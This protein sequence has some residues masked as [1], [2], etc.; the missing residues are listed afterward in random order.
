[1]LFAVI[2][3]SC[4]FIAKT[5]HE[6]I[7]LGLQ[8]GATTTEINFNW[9]SATADSD[10]S[11]VRIFKNNKIVATK[12]G[13]S[14]NASLGNRWHKVTVDGLE[15]NTQ[16]TYQVSNNGV[17]WSNGYSYKTPPTGNF[18]F[19]LVA[20]PQVATG[21]QDTASLYF[22]NPAT[23]AA[24]WAETISKI[25][26]TGAS[27]IAGNGD[28]VDALDGDESE[29]NNFFAPKQ[30]KSIPFAPVMGNHDRHCHFFYHFNLPNQASNAPTSTCTSEDLDNMSNYYYLYNRVLFIGLNT[31]PYPTTVDAATIYIAKYRNTIQAAKTTYAGKYDWI[32]VH[33]HKSTASVASHIDDDDLKQYAGAGFQTMM[34]EEG[35]NLVAAGHDHVYAKSHLMDGVLYLTLNTASGLKYYPA[36]KYPQSN[37]K[38]FTSYKP[39]YTIIDVTSST[40]TVSTYTID[41]TLVPH[42][43]FII[44]K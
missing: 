32:I 40:L 10:Q 43:Q 16:Y 9:Y 15:P 38:F 17:N 42:D 44:A 26:A 23:T 30:L 8:P 31:S 25:T 19:A 29:Y 13:S 11:I 27:F 20:D 14:N 12:T 22:S 33:H 18:K 5:P 21:S 39:E 1:M 35:I 41:N 2:A 34:S 28:Q 36:N 7:T 37:E 4:T 24:G 6:P 3:I